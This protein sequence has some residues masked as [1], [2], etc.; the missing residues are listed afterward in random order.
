MEVQ[1]E[2]P[3]QEIKR[4]RRCINDLTSLLALPA[5]WRGSEPSQI[6]QTLLDVLLRML[7]LDFAY[8]R[9]SDAFGAM[10]VEILRIAEDSKIKLS[11]QE[12]RSMLGDPLAAYA[13]GSLP[14]IRNQLAAEGIAIV[15]AQL[16]VHGEIG[17]IVLGSNRTGF[18]ERTESLL[19]SVAAN[20]ASIGLQEARLLSEQKRI[21]AELNAENQM[22]P[23]LTE[24]EIDRARP[25]GRLRRVEIG[26]ILYRPGEVGRPCFILLS[27]SLEIVQPTIHG[28]RLVTILRPGMFT[29]EAGTIAGQRTV[30]QARV[31]QAGEILEVRPED[32]RTFVAHDASL[33]EIL[34]RAFM[35]RRLM[36]IDRQLG[37]VVVIGSRHSADTLRL[38]E[39]L[40]RNSHPFS[41]IDLDMDDAYRNLLDRFGIAVSEIP[42][43][44]GNDG[45]MVLRN[46]S[47]SQLA[48]SL[49]LN[50]NIDNSSLHDLI[51]VGAGPAGLAAA[52]YAASEGID[53]LVIESHAPGGQA[54]SS[55]KIENYLGFPTGV[56]GQ[57]LATSAT[58]QA[59]KFGAKMALARAIV[60]LRCQHRPYELVMNDGTVFFA[61]TIVIATGA[62]YK[63]PTAVN[64]DRFVGH[65]I[66]YGATFLEAQLCEGEEVIVV[67]GG[68]SAGQAAVFLSQH[69][70]KVYMLVR[71]ATLSESMS[72][73][74]IARIS[75]NPSIELLCNS[76]LADLEGERALEKVS[77]VNKL[78][79]EVRSV[80]ARHL[81]IMAGA[82]PNTSWLRGRVAL[83]EKGFILTGRDL[84]LVVDPDR[85]PLWPLSRPPFM[86]ESSLPG[87]FAV[88]DVRAG[89]VKRVA[90]AVGEGAISVSMVH[91][92]LAEL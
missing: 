44:I 49:G 85:S 78:N 20:E 74:L 77:W 71:A 14:Q 48:D 89:S 90:S 73:Y 3:A 51:I 41:Y 2:D 6:V 22:W 57:E 18:P 24:A 58:K 86:L 31:I 11:A 8:A 43:V 13:Q 42:I 17:V 82:S 23:V 66:H 72:H 37:N 64:L 60:Q 40:S 88:G 26:E 63:K 39:F 21:S 28:E 79:G 36:L 35:L 38:R 55:S 33:S 30:V 59:Q 47:T 25:Y 9:L 10:P 4:L 5:I 52:V 19:L 16:G 32:L 12:V 46:P 91:R 29:G 92:A 87:V 84:P 34:L 56:S 53:A 76:E 69:A 1:L 83:D 80:K 61:R 54:G 68:N 62:Y 50:D 65:G 15:P 75:G 7:S 67:G 70:R 81:F 27:V 45:T